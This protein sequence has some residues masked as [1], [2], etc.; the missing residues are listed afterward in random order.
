MPGLDIVLYSRSALYVIDL[1]KFRQV[2]STK[3]LHPA[4]V[5]DIMLRLL[6]E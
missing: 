5:A 2:S 1:V 3:E 6:L 4:L